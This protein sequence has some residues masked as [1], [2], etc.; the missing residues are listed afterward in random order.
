MKRSLGR[1]EALEGL[2]VLDVGLRLRVPLGSHGKAHAPNQ[3]PVY[4]RGSDSSTAHP[5]QA[6]GFRF[7]AK[8]S[9]YRTLHDQ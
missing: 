5:V 7:L 8:P 6:F 1:F 2:C 3:K 9:Q 4:D